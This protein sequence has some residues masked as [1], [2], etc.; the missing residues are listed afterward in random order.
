MK[1]IVFIL[2]I[3][4]WMIQTK[5]KSFRALTTSENLKQDDWKQDVEGIQT[6]HHYI[7]HG[8]RLCYNTKKFYIGREGVG[9]R[10]PYPCHHWG[11]HHTICSAL[12]RKPLNI[13]SRSKVVKF[14]IISSQFNFI[15][16]VCRFKTVRKS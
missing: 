15:I 3:W 16:V 4:N 10:L 5:R 13:S 12:K 14:F 11:I 9:Q 7:C 6:C 1:F 2:Y 8:Q